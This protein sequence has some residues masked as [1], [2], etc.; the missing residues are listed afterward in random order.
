[1]L[2]VKE[3]RFGCQGGTCWLLRRLFCVATGLARAVDWLLDTRIVK[4][5]LARAFSHHLAV[6]RH[7]HFTWQRLLRV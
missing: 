7:V 3:A 2:V 1:M 4:G 5:G 6:A